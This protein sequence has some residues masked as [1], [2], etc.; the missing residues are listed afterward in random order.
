MN[1]DDVM[2][3]MGDAFKILFDLEQKLNNQHTGIPDKPLRE[4]DIELLKV[5]KELGDILNEMI[6]KKRI[7]WNLLENT[8]LKTNTIFV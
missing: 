1:R 7:I 8:D 6:L 5:R 3:E 2:E 4:H